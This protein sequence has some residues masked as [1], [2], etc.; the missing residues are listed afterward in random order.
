MPVGFSVVP[1]DVRGRMEHNLLVDRRADGT[2]LLLLSGRLDADTAPQV[3][4]WVDQVL[5]K[6]PWRVV[7]D[8]ARLDYI[9]SAGV[10]ILLKCRKQQQERGAQCLLLH[11]QPSVRRVLELLQLLNAEMFDSEADLDAYLDSVQRDP[12]PATED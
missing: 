5:A 7:L 11:P 9:S 12:P 3:E 2:T 4:T 10:R 8:L 6:R 1:K